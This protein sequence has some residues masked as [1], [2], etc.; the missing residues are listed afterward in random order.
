MSS[1]DILAAISLADSDSGVPG[2]E[3]S[4]EIE[5][6]DSDAAIESIKRL[7]TDFSARG[8]RSYTIV[9]SEF[10]VNG[11][12]DNM[13]SVTIKLDDIPEISWVTFYYKLEDLGIVD[14]EDI[15]FSEITARWIN[16]FFD[17]DNEIILEE[18]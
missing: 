12:G 2:G 13:I 3:I 6:K 1:I 7:L 4:A 16:D 9:S 14:P 11:S 15:D 10:Y 8:G 18:M 17:E 5:A